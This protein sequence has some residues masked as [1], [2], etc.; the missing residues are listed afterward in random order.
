[1]CLEIVE[2]PQYVE[3]LENENWSVK[4]PWHPKNKHLGTL[5]FE[6]DNSMYSR[7]IWDS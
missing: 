3:N 6:T 5:G 7:K 4:M 1:M 2:A